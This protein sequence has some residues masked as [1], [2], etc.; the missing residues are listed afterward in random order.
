MD[1]L[2]KGLGER[3]ISF[4]ET[5]LAVSVLAILGSAAMFH[6]SS[7]YRNALVNY[8]A[9]VLASD[10]KLIQQMSRTA[11]Y[12][13]GNFPS[14]EKSP[15][16]VE[17]V[18]YSGCYYMRRSGAYGKTFRKHFFPSD[19]GA[20]PT[21]IEYLSF[22]PNGNSRARRIGNVLVYYRGRGTVSR[23]V[24][25]DAAGRIRIDRQKL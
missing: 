25:V 15:K 23:K 14:M 2:V 19:I 22:Y 1:G 24:I 17:L 7:I 20:T 8:E 11:T 18:M 9:S 10:M 13:S 3:G 12:D 16:H 4:I 21:L 6:G 5:I